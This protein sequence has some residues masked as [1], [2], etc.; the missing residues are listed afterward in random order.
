MSYVVQRMIEEECDKL[1]Y[2]LIVKNRAYGNSALDPVRVFSH[3]EVDEQIRVR[4]DDKLSRLARGE[5]DD[6]E[7]TVKDLTGYLIL[8]RVS[9]RL[10]ILR[11]SPNAKRTSWTDEA[12]GEILRFFVKPHTWGV[13]TK[14]MRNEQLAREDAEVNKGR[15]TD[16]LNQ[17]AAKRVQERGLREEP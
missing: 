7:D 10:E 17:A 13:G 4:L 12:Q 8:L 9:E 14:G 11:N 16:G 3:A 2:G 15:V 5:A 1:A 6:D